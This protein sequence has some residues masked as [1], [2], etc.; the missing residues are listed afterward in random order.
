MPYLR[1]DKLL[2]TKNNSKIMWKKIVFLTAAICCSYSA[3]ADSYAKQL[4]EK[5]TNIENRSDIDPDSFAIDIK[6]LEDEL[7]KLNTESIKMSSEK[8]TTYK[9]ILRGVLATAYNSMLYSNINA[10]D[11]E[12]KNKYRKQCQSHF[13]RVLEDMPTLSRQNSND[14]EPLIMRKSGSYYYGHNMLAVMLDFRLNNDNRLTKEERDSLHYAARRVFQMNGDRNS[15]AMLR[16]KELEY[17]PE[18]KGNGDKEKQEYCKTLE[19]LVDSTKDITVGQLV[20][21]KLEIAKGIIKESHVNIRIEDNLL[22]DKPFK[23]QIQS[24]NTPLVQLQVM[25]YSGE[26]TYMIEEKHIGRVILR[27]TYTPTDDEKMKACWAKYLPTRDSLE[28]VMSLPAGKYLLRATISGDTSSVVAQITSLH[29]IMYKTP[30]G[31]SHIKVVD[32]ITGFPLSGI[33]VILYR[34][35][36]KTSKHDTFIT[37]KRG[38]VVVENE[39]YQIMRAVRDTTLLGTCKEDATDY[40]Y[41]Y[42]YEYHSE[43]ALRTIGRIYTDRELYRPGQTVHVSSMIYTMIGDETKVKTDGKYEISLRNPEGE[44]VSTDTLSPSR[45]G[46]MTCD[47]TLPK[48]KL[49]TW[50]IYL[51]TLGSNKWNNIEV[52]SIR[53][54][55]YK[56]PTYTVEFAKDTTV[57]A[58]ED[59]IEVEL[60]AKALSGMPVQGAKVSLTVEACKQGF[61]YYMNSGWQW[62]TNIDGTTNDDGKM[63]FDI[64]PAEK[65][66]IKNIIANAREKEK[67]MLRI[68]A[69]VTDNAG[70]THKAVT[71]YLIPLKP[72]KQTEETK[73]PEPLQVSKEKIYVGETLDIT[74]TPKHKDAYTIYYVVTGGKV[75]DSQEKIING[76]ITRTLKCSKEWGDGANIYIMYAKE[77]KIYYYRKTVNVPKPDKKLKL[78]WHTFRDHLTPG[79]QE[80]WTLTVK[81]KDGKPV[82]GANLLA[83]MYD[84]SLDELSSF[85]WTFQI[86]F[87]SHITSMWFRYT[88]PSSVNPLILHYS[89]AVRNIQPSEF[90]FLKQ[91][92]HEGG[93]LRFK[94]GLLYSRNSSL[95]EVTV[96]AKSVN[97]ADYAPLAAS[98]PLQGK[99][100]GLTITGNSAELDAE[101]S[102]RLQGT[103]EAD[104]KEGSISNI[105]PSIRENFNETA[106]FY[107]NITTD[108]EGHAQIQFTLPESLT[109]WKFQGFAHTDD[110]RYG[111]ISGTA[112]AN[113]DFMV[114]PQMPR[115][116]R[117]ND[118]VTIQARIQNQSDTHTAGRATMRLLSAADESKVVWKE[119]QAFY[120]EKGKTGIVTFTIPAGKL[121]EDV[122]CEI[123]ANDG[124]C[125]DGERNLLP[126]LQ[127]KEQITENI[128]FYIEGAGKKEID[129]QTL[130]NK[131]SSTATDRTLEIGYTDNPALDVFRSLRATQMPQHDNAPC[132]AA[133]LYSNTIMLDIANQLAEYNDTLI[134]NFDKAEA[135]TLAAEASAKLAAL[136]LPNGSW[137]W[138]K[139]ME[140]SPYITLAVAEHLNRLG[141]L[142]DKK[143]A[144]MLQKAMDYLDKYMLNDYQKRKAQKWSLTPSEFD[145]RYLDICKAEQNEM[146]KTYL[147]EVVKNMK[148]TTIY[149]RAKCAVILQKFGKAK[150]AVKFA[151]SVKHYLV[152]KPGFGRYFATDKAYYSWQDYRLP[153]QLAA[154]RCLQ[155]VDSK[156]NAKLLPDMQM[157]LLRQKQTQLWRNPL[158]AIDAADYL[159]T[160]SKEESLR[161]ADTLQV[162]FGT[163]LTPISPSTP[164]THLTPLS[165]I[166]P[167]TP[168]EIEKHSPGIS[169]GYVRGTFTEEAEKLQNYTTGELSIQQKFYVKQGK[170]WVETDL[171]SPLAVGSTLR[172]RN[173]IHA[174]R[175]MDFVSVKTKQPA[176]L[177][178]VRTLSGFNWFGNRGG[179]LELHDTETDVFFNWF[180]RGTTTLDLEY[181]VTR[182]GDYHSGITTA[183]CEYAPEFGGYAKTFSINVK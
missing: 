61:W 19:A 25:E 29:Q 175:D 181:Y 93:N 164:S 137:S 22:A 154:M 131:N 143:T 152:F 105:K 158:N 132:Y 169:W 89:P 146:V 142:A 9:S 34:E 45:M 77:G 5:I 1:D 28:D 49:G 33:A 75:I 130:Y 13:S 23:M 94:G 104:D 52:A 57:Y 73:E 173:I 151:E 10:F 20:S 50:N 72:V 153:T 80:T 100:S 76:K 31:K 139:G 134:Q 129:L 157:W 81:D 17:M 14:Y 56:R 117:T 156:K 120:V 163:Q 103:E 110:V 86:P 41:I 162:R 88:S 67:L 101:G 60:D 115:F 174:D 12:T 37:D 36:N 79:Q 3:M 109:T 128:P 126:V 24:A 138:F 179:Y 102:M 95:R 48:G 149:G 70:E 178:P 87:V 43:D 30:D 71:T 7:S 141:T 166:T 155:K 51:K 66:S 116:V 133:A 97:A 119:D 59:K 90:D 44:T 16:L 107:P 127:T 123:S 65:G 148:H 39:K 58:P 180:S 106:F 63:L 78:E 40:I 111:I 172:I 177:E 68:T 121:T 91:F 69:E 83:S 82:E 35:R 168:L 144:D 85:D 92:E 99:I 98:A 26:N 11:E 62:V 15:D 4:K 160:Y 125:S 135:R 74:F 84:A 118:Q 150:D 108:S 165:P 147:S 136:Q 171:S 6:I 8:R 32:R 55:E 42:S 113:K 145:L 18:G 38:E 170:E 161:A 53:V 167:S 96:K 140:S 159:L 182:S 2:K 114:Q 64:I 124:I 47:F 21:N 176:C 54:E 27:R 112:V 46:T 183:T 122:V